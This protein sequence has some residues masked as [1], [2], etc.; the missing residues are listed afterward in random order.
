MDHQYR[1]QD[2]Y[3]F[4]RLSWS[5]YWLDGY[6]PHSYYLLVVRQL[7][8]SPQAVITSPIIMILSILRQGHPSSLLRSYQR[9]PGT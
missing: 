6:C 4:T 8:E 2:G 5:S 1:T 9:A 3:E 7:L